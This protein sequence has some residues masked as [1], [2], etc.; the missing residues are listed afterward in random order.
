M[1]RYDP[2]LVIKRLVVE[3]NGAAVYDESFHVGVNV[4]RGEIRRVNQ[5]Y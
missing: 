1:M 5:R 2:T 4:I 3:R